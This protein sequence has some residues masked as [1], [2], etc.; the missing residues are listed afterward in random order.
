LIAAEEMEQ[1]ALVYLI[2]RFLDPTAG[3]IRI[4][5]HNLRWVT[6]DSL[7]AQ[8]AIVLQHNLV[9]NDTVAANIGCG[10]AS[11]TLPQ[12][13]EAAKVAHA[14]QFIQKLPR[15][16]ETLIGDMG[17]HLDIGQQFLIALARAILRD[18]ALLIVE[19]P[20]VPLTEDVKSL[21]DDTFARVLPGRTV[22]FLPHRI[23]TIRSCDRIFLLHKGQIQ[24]AGTHR[25]LLEQNELY[26][27]LHY[28]EFNELVEQL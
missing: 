22:I 26:R 13:I 6:L 5:N 4:D 8:I 24:A 28:I 25:E 17:H 19:E 16:Y 9:F 23:P 21:L 3:E 27:H 1:H 10:D 7:R 11:Y 15:G 14:H 18:P 12:I 2:P 20:A